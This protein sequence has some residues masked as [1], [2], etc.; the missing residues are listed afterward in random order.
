[1]KSNTALSRLGLLLLAFVLLATGGA[2]AQSSIHWSNAIHYAKL[3]KIAEGV[4]PTN[5]Y[6][7]ADKQAIAALGYTYQQTIY[8]SDWNSSDTVSSDT[9][10][11]YGFLATSSTGELVAV[12]RGT[13]T[14]IE[15]VDDAKFALVSNPIKNSSGYTEYG[16]SKIYSSLRMGTA[17]SATPVVSA[18]ATQA[19]AG[20]IQ[21]VTVTGHSLGGALCE[22][23]TL[24]VAHNTKIT[25]PVAYSFASPRV[26]TSGFQSDYNNTVATSYRVY[27]T[28]DIVPDVPFWPYYQVNTGFPLV[29]DSSKVSTSVACSHHL[30]TYLWLMGQEAGVDAG[31]LNAECVVND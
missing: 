8:G 1:M 9:T 5:D 2:F 3:V 11:S 10:V 7:D 12:L 14:T 17:T 16:F 13:D 28:K 15:W 20:A 6:S 21:S 23:L 19:T 25:A 18:I 27:N 31:A 26:G 30:T 4:E 24:D 22:L 29:P